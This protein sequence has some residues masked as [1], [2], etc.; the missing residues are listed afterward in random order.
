MGTGSPRSSLALWQPCS[1]FWPCA[2]WGP[3]AQPMCSAPPPPCCCP[4]SPPSWASPWASAS[5]PAPSGCQMSSQVCSGGL[6]HSRGWCRQEE[7]VPAPPGSEFPSSQLPRRVPACLPLR[8]P[9]TVALTGLLA[10]LY[11]FLLFYMSCWVKLE[12]F[13]SYTP[14]LRWVQGAPTEGWRLTP[15]SADGPL[16][17]R[18]MA[19]CC[20]RASPASSPALLQVQR[21]APGD[22]G[23]PQVRH[24]LPLH[25]QADLRWW[26]FLRRTVSCCRA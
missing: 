15:T 17:S 3:S 7:G 14:W 20:K 23:R 4:P 16:D 5:S 13:F 12:A 6:A 26:G 25:R 11:F 19:A 10:A 24:A 22:G 2:S 1:L 9:A 21:Q 8:P 18:A